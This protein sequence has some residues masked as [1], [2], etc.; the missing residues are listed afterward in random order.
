MAC[1]RKPRLVGRYTSLSDS[2]RRCVSHALGGSHA[3][4]GR[5]NPNLLG[6]FRPATEGLALLTRDVSRY[7]TYYPSVQLIAPEIRD[8]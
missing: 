4:L 7:R 6:V 2:D 3:L 8:K 1:S 5:N